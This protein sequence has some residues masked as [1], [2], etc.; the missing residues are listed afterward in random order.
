MGEDPDAWCKYHKM[1]GHMTDDCIH[2][3]NEIESLIHNGRLRR[4]VKD[5]GEGSKRCNNE[6]KDSKQKKGDDEEPPDERHTLNTI[7][8]EFAGDGESN[9]SRKKYV[10]HVMFLDYTPDATQKDEPEITFTSRDKERV[11]PHADDAMVI[12]LHM[13]N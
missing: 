5:Q 3:K 10:R 4:Y 8:G 12:T 7:S 11:W 9:S 2:W 1:K 6:P 13:F